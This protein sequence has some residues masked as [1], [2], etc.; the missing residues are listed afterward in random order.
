MKN[1]ILVGFMGTGKTVV[2]QELARRLKRE[3]VSLDELIEE[4]EKR[5]ITKIFAESGENYFRDVESQV[6][7]EISDRENLVIDA[8]GGVVIRE[9]NVKNLKKNGVLICL[10]ASPEVIFKR[11]KN[12][13]HRPLLNVTQPLERIKELLKIRE[14]YYACADYFIDTSEVSIS[15]VVEKILEIVKNK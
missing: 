9:E 5:P 1:I 4:R 12:Y 11:T 2:A 15:E 10:K 8:G 14:P 13:T 3:Y 6:V 7:K